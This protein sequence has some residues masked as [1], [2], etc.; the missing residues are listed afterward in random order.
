MSEIEID[1]SLEGHLPV[2]KPNKRFE[3]LNPIRKEKKLPT[4]SEKYQDYLVNQLFEDDLKQKL[5]DLKDKQAEEESE[6]FEQAKHFHKKARNGSWDVK[7]DD[8]VYYF[9]PELSYEL[10]GYRP[11]TA[12]EG[13]NFDPTPFCKICKTFEETGKF[14][15][16]PKDSK[17]FRDFWNEQKRRCVEGYTIGKYRITGDHYF[18]L[19]FYR[20]PK[21]NE[22]TDKAGSGRYDGFP[23]FVSKQYELFHY[24]ELCEYLS[25]DVCILK[26][27]GIGWSET[28]ASLAVRPFITTKNYRTVLTA[29]SEDHLSP[30]LQKCWAQLNWL[31]MN[32]NGGMKRSRQKIDNIWKKRASLVTKDGVEFGRFAEIEGIYADDPNKIRGD[33]CDR[34]IF[35]EAGTNKNL[36]KSVIQGRALVTLG[37][38]RIGIELAGGTGGDSGPNLAGLARIFNNPTSFNVLPYKNRYTR[39]NTVQYTGFFI[40]AYEFSLLPEY[41]DS[42]GV[43]NIELYKARLEKE[44]AKLEGQELI[45]ECAEQ[46][47]TP[48]EALLRQG[49]NIFDSEIIS[50]RLTAIRTK[51]D[52]EYE[53]P[54]KIMLLWDK[55]DVKPTPS[56]SGKI[57][58]VEPPQLDSGNKPYNNLYVA[59]IDAIDQGTSQSATDYDVSDFCIVIKRRAFGM[60]PPKYV[61][62]YKDR[63]KDIREAFDNALKL[64]IWYNCKAMVEYTKISIQQ[65]FAAKGKSD[66]FMARPD[67]AIINKNKGRMQKK[68]IGLPATVAVINHGLELISMYINDYCWEIDIEEIL[69]QMLN[70]SYDA[71][72]KF[73]IIAALGQCEAADEELTGVTPTTKNNLSNEWEDIGYYTDSKGYKQFGVI[74]P[75]QNQNIGWPR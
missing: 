63:P 50:N 66:L 26:C 31:N 54:K 24:I 13:L 69:E 29:D 35:D 28:L 33:R 44:R 73:D 3:G 27:R 37:G 55:Q 38:R 59:G 71:K 41:V 49:N 30:V 70:Y 52:K 1:K 40:P 5:Q 12:T 45:I 47:F 6:Y 53:K 18:F 11:I 14:C 74:N 9:D 7:K 4:F 42:R 72:R 43:T 17:P 21:V 62:M 25:H 64:L 16:Y 19:N 39:D 32:T 10:T 57:I 34:L 46:C 61:A 36:I 22:D 51:L 20:L 56:S 60:Q 8:E 65:Y 58:V 68:L 2:T 48:D 23:N 67:Y 75:N 15:E